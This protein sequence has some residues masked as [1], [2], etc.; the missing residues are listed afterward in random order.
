MELKTD[1]EHQ[2]DD[3]ELRE[4]LGDVSVG[5]EAGGIRP[6]N[7]A[8]EQV[9]DNRGKAQAMCGVPEQESRRQPSSQGQNQVEFMHIDTVPRCGPILPVR[10]CGCDGFRGRG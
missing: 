1:A 3:A 4:L 10:R 5:D 2:Q 6:D 7:R 9:A 8:S